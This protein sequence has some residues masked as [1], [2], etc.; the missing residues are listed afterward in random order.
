MHIKQKQ[1]VIPTTETYKSMLGKFSS[2]LDN[3]C[4]C[5]YKSNMQRGSHYFDLLIVSVNIATLFLSELIL[6]G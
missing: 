2:K 5:D 6:N 1:I 3:V 4:E